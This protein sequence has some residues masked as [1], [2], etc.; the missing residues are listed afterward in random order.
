MSGALGK[1]ESGSRQF[2]GGLSDAS[3]KFIGVSRL[4]KV[5]LIYV[6]KVYHVF[7]GALGIAIEFINL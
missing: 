7:M 3:N 6:S 1:Y 2:G 4:Y 5:N